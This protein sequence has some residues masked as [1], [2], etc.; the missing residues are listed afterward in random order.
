MNQPTQPQQQ[1]GWDDRRGGF[2]GGR[3]TNQQWRQRE[4]GNLQRQEQF[5]DQLFDL[6]HNLNQAR[7][8]DKIEKKQEGVRVEEEAAREEGKVPTP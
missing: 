4:P 2:H 3:S 7:D 6:R 1:G 5:R 8:Q